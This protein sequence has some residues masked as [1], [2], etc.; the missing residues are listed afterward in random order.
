M[1]H[2][3]CQWKSQMNQLHQ[4][5]MRRHCPHLMQHRYVHLSFTMT[6]KSVIVI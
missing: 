4:Q 3:G 1:S 2:R 5:L 6:K